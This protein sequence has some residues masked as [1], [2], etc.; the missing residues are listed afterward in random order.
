M[1][2]LMIAQFLLPVVTLAVCLRWLQR[3]RLQIIDRLRADGYDPELATIA[4]IA[5]FQANETGRRGFMRRWEMRSLQR[6][7]RDAQRLNE[8]F[9][10]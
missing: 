4:A 9:F 3:K 1:R 7:R 10:P 5:A 6:M 8:S 2:Y